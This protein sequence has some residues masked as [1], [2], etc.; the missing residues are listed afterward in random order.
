M[1]HTWDGTTRSATLQPQW[2]AQRGALID[3]AKRGDWENMLAILH[4]ENTLVNTWR[5]DGKAW[6][7][8]LHHAAYNGAPLQVVQ[9]LIDLGA[10]RTLRTAEGERAAEIAA[11]RGHT[12]LLTLLEP[13]YQRT[14]PPD[15]L[16]RIQGHF[17]AVI[18]GR[19]RDLVEGEKLRLPELEPLLEYPQE[20]T[21]FAIP[22]MYGGFSY[23]IETKPSPIL[24]AESWCRV[25]GGSGQRHAVSPFGSLLTEEGFV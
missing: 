14:V 8:P 5:P 12:H 20:P 3:A 15:V 11:R 1:D 10:W 9:S 16:S 13:V 7:A 25:A 24:W 6:Y 19:A 23:W 2:A 21:W 22:G 17:H 18:L 4:E